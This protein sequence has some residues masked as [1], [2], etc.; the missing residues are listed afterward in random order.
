MS[1]T[2]IYSQEVKTA[3]K[4]SW[5][6]H[7]E[8]TQSRAFLPWLTNTVVLKKRAASG[9][10]WC[11]LLASLREHTQ[12]RMTEI[13]VGTPL[14]TQ[15]ISWPPHIPH[16]FCTLCSYQERMTCHVIVM[17]MV[18]ASIVQWKKLEPT[19]SNGN[20]ILKR[21]PVQWTLISKGTLGFESVLSPRGGSCG[22]EFL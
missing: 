5:I 9:W 8:H 19:Q 14:L 20:F 11:Q 1:K 3:S 18:T 15:C 7:S 16:E 10:P 4:Q 13:P 22:G 6:I 12:C 17:W 2:T 21:N